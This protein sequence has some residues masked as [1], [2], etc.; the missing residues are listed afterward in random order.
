MLDALNWL[1]KSTRH[2]PQPLSMGFGPCEQKLLVSHWAE[3]PNY[4]RR[5][6]VRNPKTDFAGV[7]RSGLLTPLMTV[8][9]ELHCSILSYGKS[10]YLYMPYVWDVISQIHRK[11]HFSYA[12]S[13]SVCV[14]VCVCVCARSVAKLY[15]NLC[16]PRDWS[17]LRFSQQEYWSGLP[18][19]PPGGLADPG[20]FI[21]PLCL[22]G[23]AVSTQALPMGYCITDSWK[24]IF[25]LCNVCFCRF[26]IAP[27]PRKQC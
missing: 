8:S 10:Y 11:R 26:P 19:P 27:L 23:K 16:N 7:V 25:F 6:I 5:W 13:I 20:T 15:L 24:M 21:V 1:L 4:S 2:T 12:T 17:F 14:C 3:H 22:I 18:Y 9:V